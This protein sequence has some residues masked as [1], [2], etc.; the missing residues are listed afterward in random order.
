M[1]QEC[2]WVSVSHHEF[3]QQAPRRAAEK[4]PSGVLRELCCLLPTQLGERLESLRGALLGLAAGPLS[5][6]VCPLIFNLG[7]ANTQPTESYFASISFFFLFF[8]LSQTCSY[9]V[10]QW[11]LGFSNFRNGVKSHFLSCILYGS[12]LPER[13]STCL[14]VFGMWQICL[15]T[16]PKPDMMPWDLPGLYQPPTRET[17]VGCRWECA[18]AE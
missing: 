14:L 8:L 16:L 7:E 1:P 17:N 10:P 9:C 18:M 2:S 5:L 3:F 12:F 11:S 13:F 6:A 15:F 4:V